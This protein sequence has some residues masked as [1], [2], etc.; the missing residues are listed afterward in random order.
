MRLPDDI[1]FRVLMCLLTATAWLS[2]PNVVH[3]GDD[4]VI[5][6]PGGARPMPKA[7]R[8]HG[9]QELPIQAPPP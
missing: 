8:A 3:A 5:G 7:T 9:P 4:D 2:C 6:F 1:K